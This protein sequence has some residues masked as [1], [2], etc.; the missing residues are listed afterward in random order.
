[1]TLDGEPFARLPYLDV[2]NYRP[3]DDSGLAV[4][5]R[6]AGIV[7]TDRSG[8][9]YVFPCG[10]YSHSL[11]PC[12]AHYDHY[13]NQIRYRYDEDGRL[14]TLTDSFNRHLVFAYDV[15]SR[16]AEIDAALPDGRSTCLVRYEYD[17]DDLAA[18]VDANGSVTRYEYASHLLT[19]VTDPSG[20]DL[21]YQY[22]Q[23]KRCVRTWLSGGVWDRQL[24]HDPLGQRVVV[25]N[26]TGYSVVYK[27]NGKG[28]VVSD[29]DALG[30]LHEDV[31]DQ[32]DR[33][34]LRSGARSGSTI[35]T[36]VPGSRTVVM[37][38][39]G[40]ETV[41]QLNANDQ[42]TSQRNY[43]ERF[44]NPIRRPRGMTGSPAPT[45][46]WL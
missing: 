30:R 26:P 42:G 5:R 17:R 16:L 35:I 9:T 23:D 10:D 12:A 29:R 14:R 15:R 18:V 45:G 38:R 4:E 41:F 44:G 22:D 1:M 8:N 3:A 21:Y 32:N 31:L 19:R 11:I 13:R 27:H 34:L 39:G 43:K 36:R 40:L 20:R 25:T 2:G 37:S 6:E 7:V 33:L 24:S 46:S 28:V